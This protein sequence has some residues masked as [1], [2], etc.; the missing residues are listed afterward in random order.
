MSNATWTDP[1]NLIVPNGVIQ[2]SSDVFAIL[3][4]DTGGAAT[5]SVKLSAD[6][7]APA[8]YWGARTPLLWDTYNAL[9]IMTVQEFKA[10]VD[11]LSIERGRQPV[12]SVTAFKNSLL[13]D[14]TMG[15]WEFVAANGLQPVQSGEL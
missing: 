10:Y 13:M 11:Q 12:G 5:F 2:N 7:S 4:P 9:K 14:E 8:T 15:F 3:D 1:L 6:G